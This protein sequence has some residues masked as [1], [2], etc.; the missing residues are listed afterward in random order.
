M[1]EIYYGA[2]RD[3]GKI[4]RVISGFSAN[5][6]EYIAY[7]FNLTVG[8]TLPSPSGVPGADYPNV[9]NSID[10]VL[11]FGSYRK[12]FVVSSGRYIIEGIGASKG[13]FNPIE[14]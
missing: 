7:H 14:I 3:S 1:E 8:D 10:S 9:I 13:L 6:S 5:P 12:R 2:I 11:V 4:V